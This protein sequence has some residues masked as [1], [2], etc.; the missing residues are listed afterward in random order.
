[1]QGL[2]SLERIN[3]IRINPSCPNQLGFQSCENRKRT[4]VE[5]SMEAQSL[6]V[7][8]KV[9]ATQ[10]SAV[11]ATM[12]YPPVY[13]G[14]YCDSLNYQTEEDDGK[15]ATIADGRSSLAASVNPN[16]KRKP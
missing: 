1:M 6:T 4:T 7:S 10:T 11:A 8:R 16:A 12:Q 3:T 14:R 15:K 13:M 9:Q 5:E 2:R